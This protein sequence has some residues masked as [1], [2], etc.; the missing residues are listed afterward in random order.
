MAADPG[1]WVEVV[2]A[3]SR[4]QDADGNPACYPGG[5]DFGLL[6]DVPIVVQDLLLL[7]GGGPTRDTS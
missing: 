7:A 3:A 5:H 1:C 6:T 4:Q 2:A